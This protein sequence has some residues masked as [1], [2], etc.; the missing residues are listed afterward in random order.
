MM[1]TN[2]ILVYMH[3]DV[4]EDFPTEYKHCSMMFDNADGSVRIEYGGET[5]AHYDKG[6]FTK[7]VW[8]IHED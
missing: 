3:E 1:P 4:Q 5:I 7:I 2:R 8:E 6:E